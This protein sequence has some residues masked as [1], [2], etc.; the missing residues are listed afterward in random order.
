VTKIVP[1][2]AAVA[3]PGSLANYGPTFNEGKQIVLEGMGPYGLQNDP[4]NVGGDQMTMQAQYGGGKAGFTVTPLGGFTSSNTSPGAF[5]SIVSGWITGGSL[6]SP[7][8]GGYA[9]T[10]TIMGGVKPL[11]TATSSWTYTPGGGSWDAAYDCWLSSPGFGDPVK[12]GY[13]LMVW[14]GHNTA[15]PIGYPGTA[16]TITASGAPAGA[17][18]TVSTG[19][20]GTGQPVVSYLINSNVASVTNLSL[21]PFFNDAATNRGIPAGAYLLSVQAGFELY[22]TGTWTTSSYNIT[23]Q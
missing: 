9:G 13:E 21:L 8:E 3:A 4:F 11:T 5:P 14:L 22:N 1:L 20:N 18:W 23:L 10:S 17:T 12:A 19:T 6:V 2:T 15:N 16:V 7:A